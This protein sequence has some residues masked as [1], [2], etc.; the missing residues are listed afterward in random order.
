MSIREWKNLDLHSAT[1]IPIGEKKERKKKKGPPG[2]HTRALG[3]ISPPRVQ[4]ISMLSQGDWQRPPHNTR[5][6]AVFAVRI[7]DRGHGGVCGNKLI[8]PH[9]GSRSNYCVLTLRPHVSAVDSLESGDNCGITGP[10]CRSTMQVH[11]DF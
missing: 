9:V 6:N 1:Q 8:D 2:L 3:G 5:N 11:E 10:R 4:T 7:K